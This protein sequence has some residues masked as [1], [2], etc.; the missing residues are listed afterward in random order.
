MATVM[1][2]GLRLEG[3]KGHLFLLEPTSL[4]LPG[5]LAV[6]PT[7]VLSMRHVFPYQVMNLSDEDIWL[8]PGMRVGLLTQVDG[9]QSDETC[10]MQF[11][12]ISADTGEVSIDRHNEEAPNFQSILDQLNVGGSLEQQRQLASMF[13][14]YSLV[15]D[16]EDEDLGYTEC[17]I[18]FI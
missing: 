5:D 2:R 9:I 1:A 7:L 12:R 14:K 16:T 4:R 17:S 11:Q 15:F 6:V 3:C 13:A 10:D 8:K 18:K